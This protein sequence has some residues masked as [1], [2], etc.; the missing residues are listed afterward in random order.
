MARNRPLVQKLVNAMVKALRY[1]QTHSASEIADRTP[2]AFHTPDRATYVRALAQAKPLFT[3]DGRMP[4]DG[5]QAVRRV[6]ATID[7]TI[8]GKPVDLAKTYT[9]D[10]V[11]AVR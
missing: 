2:D 5:P 10:F 1:I 6:L 3:P 11:S 4:A 8:Q 9:V 7:R